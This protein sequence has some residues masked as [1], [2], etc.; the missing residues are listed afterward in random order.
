MHRKLTREGDKHRK[1]LP[2]T[3]A[4]INAVLERLRSECSDQTLLNSIHFGPTALTFVRRLLM[5][6]GTIVTDTYLLAN[7][8]DTSLLGQNGARV[9]CFIDEPYVVSLAEARR[10]TR[11]EVAVDHA[12]ALPGPKLMVVGS[13]PT[14]LHRLVQ[15]RQSAPM[16]DVCVLTALSG[17]ASAI[18]LKERLWES[19]LASIVVRGKKG[20]AAVTA[21]L[22]NAI[23]A[24]VQ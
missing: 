7:D 11:A 19:D 18:Q 3:T 22:L 10:A 15:R 21:M 12:L 5:A 9:M 13:A 16:T 24:E 6:G 4:E 1:P 23:L 14:A 2:F 20:G 17:F 8:V